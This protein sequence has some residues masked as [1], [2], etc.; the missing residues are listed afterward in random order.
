MAR[1]LESLE[2]LNNEYFDKNVWLKTWIAVAASANCSDVNTPSRYA[3]RCL[4]DF[5]DR[6]DNTIHDYKKRF[7]DSGSGHKIN[8]KITSEI[9]R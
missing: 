5:K 4:K 1:S 3:D 2:L 7:E 8:N 9:R 6:F